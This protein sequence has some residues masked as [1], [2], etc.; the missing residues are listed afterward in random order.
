MEEKENIY[1][2]IKTEVEE[3]LKNKIEKGLNI[4]R[5][6]HTIKENK[7]FRGINT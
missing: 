7:N 4:E 5:L 6:N 3:L 1:P 2:V